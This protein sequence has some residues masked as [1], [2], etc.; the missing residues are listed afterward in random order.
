MFMLISPAKALDE[1]SVSQY[2]ISVTESEFLPQAEQLAAILKE[3]SPQELADLM[4]LSD[5]LAELNFERYQNWKVPFPK[6]KSKPAA[7]LFK[8]DVYQGLDAPSLSASGLQYAQS[9]WGF[10]QVYMVYL[11]PWIA[12]CL[13]DWKWGPSWK[14]L[15]GKTS[16]PFGEKR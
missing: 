10:F 4:K 15:Q 2:P 3:K 13:I 5:Q 7:F 6:D 16:M 12:F 14:T 8:G 11:N 1:A 9:I